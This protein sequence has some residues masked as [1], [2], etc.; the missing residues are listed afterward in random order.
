MQSTEYITLALS[1]HNSSGRWGWLWSFGC[2]FVCHSQ[3]FESH[4]NV[5]RSG[6][7][8]WAAKWNDEQHTRRA[9]VCSITLTCACVCGGRV[10]VRGRGGGVN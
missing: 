2:R 10:G 4:A 3:V 8:G 7:D 6:A 9:Q 5:E 1:K